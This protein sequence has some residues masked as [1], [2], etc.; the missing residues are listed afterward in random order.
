M[1]TV[2]LILEILHI[3]VSAAALLLMPAAGREEV[4]A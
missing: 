3:V 2:T 1:K 4:W